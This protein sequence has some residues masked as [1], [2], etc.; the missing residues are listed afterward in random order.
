ML[1]LAPQ[2]VRRDQIAKASA[3]DRAAV[4]ALIFDRGASFPWRSDDARL[5]RQGVIGAAHL[6]TPELGRRIVDSVVEEAGRVCRQL[7]DNFAH[8]RPSAALN[9]G[10]AAVLRARP[11]PRRPVP[12]AR[13]SRHSGNPTP[14]R[15]R[16]K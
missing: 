15:P 16:K 2:L 4:E 14:P 10:A 6:A 5:A 3:P 1:A 11:Q 9:P 7:L 13:T 8:M 12:P